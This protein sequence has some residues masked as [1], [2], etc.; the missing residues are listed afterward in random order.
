MCL[1]LSYSIL[2][3][4]FCPTMLR[5][6]SVPFFLQFREGAHSAQLFL[7]TIR[8]QNDHRDYVQASLNQKVWTAP[9][10]RLDFCAASRSSAPREAA[11]N[12]I[13]DRIDKLLTMDHAGP[14]G[15]T[16]LRSWQAEREEEDSAVGPACC[17]S[18]R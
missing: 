8:V 6:N 2:F 12:L 18:L 9:E 14:L 16:V 15:T 13:P 10:H 3:S 5:R 11:A 7:S 1:S 4:L 17:A